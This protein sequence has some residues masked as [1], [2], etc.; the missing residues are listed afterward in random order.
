VKSKI[1][2][3]LAVFMVFAVVMSNIPLMAATTYV[4]GTRNVS[5][6]EVYIGGDD[7]VEVNLSIVGQ[8][9]VNVVKP[10]DVILVLDKS[11]SMQMDP[12]PAR[13]GAMIESAKE[14]IDLVDFDEHR[15][16]VVDY[17]GEVGSYNLSADGTAIKSYIDSIKCSGGTYTH[18]A[19]RKA[20][21]ILTTQG[22]E[23]AQP[24]IILLTDGE[25]KSKEWA[26]QAATEA[27]EAGIVFY[28][29]ALLGKNVDPTTSAENAFLKELATTASH[30]HFVLGS[31]GLIDIYRAIVKEIGIASAY[32]VEITETVPEG[33]EIV[34]GSYEHNIPQ[35]TLEGNTLKWNMLELKSNTLELSYKVKLKDG[36]EPG[37]YS[38][39]NQITYKDFA[40]RKCTYNA[41]YT[42][43]KVKHIPPVIDSI[44]PGQGDVAG[45]EAI[46]IVGNNFRPGLTVKFGTTIVNDAVLVDSK[47]IKLTAPAAANSRETV[48]VVVTN[49]DNQSASIEYT[50]IGDPVVNTMTPNVGPFEGGTIVTFMGECIDKD[51][52]VYF[53]GAEAT[54]KSSVDGSKLVVVTPK[55]TKSGLV[56]VVLVNAE[57]TTTTIKDGFEYLE[58]AM[59]ELAI[60]PNTVEVEIGEEQQFTV[61]ALLSDGSEKDLTASTTGTQYKLNSTTYATIDAEGKLTVKADAIEGKTITVIAN[62]AGYTATATVTLKDSRTKLVG[63]QFDSA[64]IEV[65]AGKTHQLKV[66]ADYSDGTQQEISLPCDQ[67]TLKSS[68]S[69]NVTVDELA[70]VSVAETAVVGKEFKVTGVYGGFT[71]TV[72]VKVMEPSVKV[73]SIEITPA[74]LKIMQGD[75]QALTVH[76]VYNTGDK[77]D[78]TAATSGITYKSNSTS[79]AKVDAD[80]TVTVSDTAA[81]GSQATITVL[82]RSFVE[83]ITV[84][85]DGVAITGIEADVE[86]V[87]IEPGQTHQLV[88]YEN[89]SDGSQKDITDATH[90]TTY[91]STNKSV[92]NVDANGLITVADT[93]VAG[94][95]VTIKA[96][97]GSYYDLVTVIVDGILLDGIEADVDTIDIEQGETY[98]LETY[99]VYS[100][101]SKVKLDPTVDAVTFA[102]NKKSTVA[103][104]A[105]GKISV[106]DTATVGSTATITVMYNGYSAK[107]VVTVLEASNTI[108]YLEAKESPLRIKPG[109]SKDL[110][111]EAVYTDGSRKDISLNQ[112]EA[113]Y[114]SASSSIA[115]VTTDGTVTVKD[116]AAI[117]KETT[118]TVT[119]R[120]HI[121]KVPLI[122]D[123]VYRV[124]IEFSETSVEVPVGGTYN[125]TLY[126]L[127]SDG[128]KDVIDLSGVTLKT[129][130]KSIATV[131]ADGTVTIQTTA[132]G[133][134]A[135]ITAIYDGFTTVLTVNT[136]A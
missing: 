126:S 25:P 27:K 26:I 76:A 113:T 55:A 48:K 37:T 63:I 99:A 129:N 6:N 86:E 95:K 58:P 41:G 24:V 108:E 14:F 51:T 117:G 66:L 67:L 133:K 61:K 89:Y 65:E 5:A 56:D 30:H 39:T 12:D 1:K 22:R 10:N 33:F 15:V 100:D 72:V 115:T 119:Y 103:V 90:G 31:V 106:V 80:G 45:G 107:V 68:S 130:A 34:P 52:K 69:A 35:P 29:I 9:P 135:R 62:N 109:A 123:G 116:T 82:Y 57:G 134:T 96:F 74:D 84:T 59:V 104:D 98:T 101:G 73:E 75:S 38:I 49:D 94:T 128:S 120:G 40:G 18:D 47:T 23:D 16:G 88:I 42:D 124:G 132:T 87:S 131:D 28:T 125:V 44:T 43:I 4:T 19:I 111:V 11:G 91:T 112:G 77:Q 70:L 50:Y 122:V 114:K 78:I 3:L 13:F 2:N 71:A 17:S 92:A 20:S 7:E 118:I 32:D 121:L 93:A 102:S 46:T 110:V 36:V 85:V 81:V 136:V 105:Q 60:S 21:E 64:E 54:F 97:N 53:D 83:K 79:I 8:P 127:N